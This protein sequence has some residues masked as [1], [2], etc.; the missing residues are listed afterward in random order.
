MSDIRSDRVTEKRPNFPLSR[1]STKLR[2]GRMGRA[3]IHDDFPPVGELAGSQP[4]GSG[5]TGSGCDMGHCGAVLEED[6]T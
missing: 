6:V 3:M 4:F 2:P 1:R 5:G